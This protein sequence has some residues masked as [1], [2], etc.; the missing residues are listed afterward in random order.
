MKRK[1]RIM[2]L[3]INVKRS[4]TLLLGMMVGLVA[5]AG[6][7]VVGDYNAS[8]CV[9]PSG[10]A[11]FSIP[12]ECPKGVN[13]ME[14]KIS[15]NYNSQSGYGNAGYG[16]NVAAT[17]VITKALA[18]P[19]YNGKCMPINGDYQEEY[20]SLDGQRLIKYKEIS[21]SEVEFRT[22][23]DNYNRIV[24]YGTALD[25]YFKVYTTDGKIL[26]YSQL[27]EGQRY[28]H[29]NSGWYLT[30]VEDL[31]G[32][33]MTYEYY[34][35]VT[36]NYIYNIDRVRLKSIQYGG[37]STVGNAHTCRVDFEYEIGDIPDYYVS[38]YCKKRCHVFSSVKTY[39][40]NTL[41]TKYEFVYGNT[42]NSTRLK[43]IKK[44]GNNE[45]YLESVKVNW[46]EYNFSPTETINRS[47]A[48]GDMEHEEKSLNVVTQDIQEAYYTKKQWLATDY[49]NDGYLDVLSFCK[50]ERIVYD[51]KGRTNSEFYSFIHYYK[52]NKGVLEYDKYVE[53]RMSKDFIVNSQMGAL[54][55]CHFTKRN[56]Q[57]AILPCLYLNKNEGKEGDVMVLIN[58]M[59]PTDKCEIPL[60][61]QYPATLI[62][63]YSCADL[64]KDGYDDIIIVERGHNNCRILWGGSYSSLAEQTKNGKI[65]NYTYSGGGS[66]LER[67]AVCDMNN[68]GLLDIA[69]ICND[70]YSFIRNNG[71][72]D[73]GTSYFSS[74]LFRKNP[75]KYNSSNGNVFLYGDFNGDG[76]P[77]FFKTE[78]KDYVIYANEVV[79]NG[80]LGYSEKRNL[81]HGV[82]DLY[83]FTMD[84]NGDGTLDVCTVAKDYFSCHTFKQG[85]N[86]QLYGI[87][88]PT[89]VTQNHIILGDFDADGLPEI[90]SVGEPLMKTTPTTAREKKNAFFINKFITNGDGNYVSS[91]STPLHTYNFTY[92]PLTDKSVYTR[93]KTF[94]ESENLINLLCPIYVVKEFN[95]DGVKSI[96][97]YS[98]AVCEVTGKGFLGF[99]TT[100]CVDDLSTTVQTNGYKTN[101]ALIYPSSTTVASQSGVFKKTIQSFSFPLLTGTKAYHHFLHFVQ[102]EYTYYL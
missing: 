8:A 51:Y 7:L 79:S 70:G 32:N 78:N 10:A 44:Y 99:L 27:E 50:K 34:Y 5:T 38:K 33:Y 85:R 17:S 97:S 11:S 58:L 61:G 91:I 22:E 40:N 95:V 67:I 31:Y 100:K 90:I 29:G 75:V 2:Q 46:N 1:T 71:T 48:I 6:N 24:R 66:Y 49:N 9:S 54:M 42:N 63:H 3:H 15:L 13:G 92:A 101:P 87:A 93:T 56:E 74:T 83:G 55:S 64:N 88:L 86:N 69:L 39:S 94:A 84:M 65:T 25:Y 89:P 52:N 37:N 4:L 36:S 53:E 98:N 62:P 73:N 59:N 35:Y 80:E 14:P 57:N 23:N 102:V 19:Y 20:L 12:I 82:T 28:Y 47:I 30:K 77:D 16:W 96:Y 26:T 45:D 18:T 60:S 41:N 81:W 72:T 43:E 21:E 68:D 76:S